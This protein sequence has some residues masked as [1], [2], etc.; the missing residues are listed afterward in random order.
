[1]TK[2]REGFEKRATSLH[3]EPAG[4]AKNTTEEDVFGGLIP[5]VEKGKG[6]DQLVLGYNKPVS[7][8]SMDRVPLES[9][10]D[11]PESFS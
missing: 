1:M 7:G 2:F 4:G 11:R 9:D 6:L 5:K 10:Q 3:G 8:M